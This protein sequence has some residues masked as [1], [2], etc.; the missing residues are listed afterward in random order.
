MWAF[1]T[2]PQSAV[3]FVIM[4]SCVVMGLSHMVQPRMWADFFTGLHAQGTRGV[5][6][7][8]FALEL[9]AVLLIV[10]LHQVWTWPGVVVTVYGYLL[11]AKIVL[12]MLAPQIGLRSMQMA[13]GGDHRFVVG[14]AV[15]LAVGAAAGAALFLEP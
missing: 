8:T 14:G 12:S 4:V 5:I 10:T 2:D 6:V 15:L 11:G 9:W 3:Q 7:R 1:I 13:A